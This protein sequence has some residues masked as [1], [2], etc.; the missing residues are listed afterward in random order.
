MSKI[1]VNEIR[2]QCGTTVTLGGSGETVT[3]AAPTVNLGASGGTVALA[4][5]SYFNRFWN[6]RNYVVHN[7]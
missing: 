2:P 7:S 4:C 1:E 6:N 3:V 5:G